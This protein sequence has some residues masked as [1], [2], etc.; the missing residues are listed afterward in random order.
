MPN[1]AVIGADVI[2]NGPLGAIFGQRGAKLSGSTDMIDMTV[3]EGFPNKSSR[4]GWNGVFTI[5]CDCLLAHGDEGYMYW[6]EQSQ[7]RA[8]IDV[9]IHIGDGGEVLEGEGG[10]GGVVGTCSAY[11]ETPDLDAP[12][13]GEGTMN[14]KFIIDGAITWASA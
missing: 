5:E 11:V 9:E 10:E 13:A 8:P 1:T 2:I 14:L 3:K 4:P 12:Q 7:L 6:F